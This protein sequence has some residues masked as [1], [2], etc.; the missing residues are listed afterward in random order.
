MKKW[1]MG[2]LWYSQE[3]TPKGGSAEYT[4]R[5]IWTYML[6]D[7]DWG[8]WEHFFFLKLSKQRVKR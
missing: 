6:I 2:A 4:G 8:K 5:D 3:T 1:C 7:K